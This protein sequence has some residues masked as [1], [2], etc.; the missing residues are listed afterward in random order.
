VAKYMVMHL[1]PNSLYSNELQR[2][3]AMMEY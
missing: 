2:M 1:Y 3:D